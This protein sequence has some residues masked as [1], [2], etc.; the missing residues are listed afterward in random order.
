MFLSFQIGFWLEKLKFSFFKK[1]EPLK[2]IFKK[3]LYE[4]SSKKNPWKKLIS[5]TF[6]KLFY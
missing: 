5:E 1:K 3:N 4:N 6:R 2:K